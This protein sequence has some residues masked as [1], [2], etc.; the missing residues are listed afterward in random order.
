MIVNGKI[1]SVE[2]RRDSD[3]QMSGLSVNISMDGVKVEGKRVEV[4]YTYIATYDE[5]VGE[6]KLKGVLYAN[7]E[8]KAA[9]K[10]KERWEKEKKLP[11]EFAEVVIN[12]INFTCSTN[13]IFATRVVNLAPPMVPPRISIGKGGG[14]EGA[15]PAS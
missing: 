1:T 7:E 4:S 11:E 5:K 15:K 13:G 2:A 14:N 8:E 10:I 3:A 12:T 6:L 9:K